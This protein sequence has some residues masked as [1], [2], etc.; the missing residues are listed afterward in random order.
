MS[1]MN[2]FLSLSNADLRR[3]SCLLVFFAAALADEHVEPCGRLW[4]IV[5]EHERQDADEGR[6]RN[7]G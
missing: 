4:A 3:M 1:S 7:G 2:D 6:N 5:A